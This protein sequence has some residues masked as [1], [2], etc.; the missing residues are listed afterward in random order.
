MSVSPPDRNVL[1]RQVADLRDEMAG[2][3]KEYAEHQERHIAI[4]AALELDR[5]KTVDEVTDE[6]YDDKDMVVQNLK[7]RVFEQGFEDGV[8][9]ARN[10]LDALLRQVIEEAP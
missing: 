10:S 4:V 9:H 6:A 5:G 2:L 1:A 3:R 7:D 8:R